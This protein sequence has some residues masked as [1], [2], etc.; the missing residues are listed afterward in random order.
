MHSQTGMKGYGFILLLIISLQASSQYVEKTINFFGAHGDG[1][2][3]DQEAFQ[4]AADYFNKRG[5]NGKLIIPTGVYIVG[6]QQFNSNTTKEAVYQGS[7][8]LAFKN[9]HDL[10][11]EGGAHTIIKY[12]NGLRYGSFNPVTGLPNS[13]GNNF[14]PI[15]LLH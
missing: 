15:L 14:F 2:T 8:L 4:K 5:G 7:D 9:V 6:K 12:A 13:N 10:V 3:N 1:I 11:I